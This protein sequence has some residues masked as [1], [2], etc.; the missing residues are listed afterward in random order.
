MTAN[1]QQWD[2]EKVKLLRWK[3]EKLQE[4]NSTLRNEITT[5]NEEESISNLKLGE[6]NG[7]YR[8]EKKPCSLEDGC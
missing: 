6:L 3:C 8:T 5:L 4:E 2:T 1:H 7:D